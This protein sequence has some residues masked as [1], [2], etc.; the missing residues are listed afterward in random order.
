MSQQETP[1]TMVGRASSTFMSLIAMSQV[2]DCF[3]QDIWRKRHQSS[4]Y[5]LRGR[6]RRNFGSRVLSDAHTDTSDCYR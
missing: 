1:P 6:A 3:S 4:F 2:L 5:R